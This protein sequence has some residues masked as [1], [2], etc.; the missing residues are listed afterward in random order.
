MFQNKHEELVKR[1]NSEEDV[2]Q[3][4]IDRVSDK[5]TFFRE[6]R[7]QHISTI[8]IHR[9]QPDFHTSAYFIPS[10]VYI[11]DKIDL[12][13]TLASPFIGMSDKQMEL[14]KDFCTY[15]SL[16]REKREKSRSRILQMA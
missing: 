10:E 15:S 4:S 13:W 12:M 8:R 3:S 16:L 5:L 14:T 9:I 2:L 11:R 6:F 1:I 7:Q